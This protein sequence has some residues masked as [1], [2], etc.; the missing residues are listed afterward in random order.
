MLL[1]NENAS[2]VERSLSD[3]KNTLIVERTKFKD[4]TLLALRKAKEH[5]RFCEVLVVSVHLRKIS[6]KV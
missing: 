1:H 5:A 4:S 3:N 6:E 2:V